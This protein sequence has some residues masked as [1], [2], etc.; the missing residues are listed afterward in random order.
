MVSVIIQQQKD[1]INRIG[2]VEKALRAKPNLNMKD[3]VL[4]V[5][6]GLLCCERKAKEYIRIAKWRIENENL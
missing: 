4:E 6:D 2:I 3:F 1:K 5:C